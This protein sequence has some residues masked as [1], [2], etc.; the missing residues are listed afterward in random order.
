[1]AFVGSS[2]P[3]SGYMHG[4]IHITVMHCPTRGT[5]PV[6]KVRIHTQFELPLDHLRLVSGF[7]YTSS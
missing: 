7:Q 4:C 5:H 1:M 3:G 2:D 6:M